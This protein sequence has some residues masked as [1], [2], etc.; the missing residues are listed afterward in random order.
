MMQRNTN[1]PSGIQLRRSGLLSLAVALSLAS[2]D[3]VSA[4]GNSHQSN[5]LLQNSAASVNRI[6]RADFTNQDGSEQ[7]VLPKDKRSPGRAKALTFSEPEDLA[8]SLAQVA[9]KNQGKNSDEGSA[10]PNTNW[11]AQ[12]EGDTS[13]GGANQQARVTEMSSAAKWM[14]DR[15]YL[16]II[17]AIASVVGCC[18]FS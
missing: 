4:V 15:P 3:P 5:N 16:L 13:L 9:S 12:Q 8:D 7:G 10:G 6:K 14:Q 1:H 17:L 18:F 2:I 11:L